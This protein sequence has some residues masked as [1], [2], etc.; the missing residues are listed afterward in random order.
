ML[1][2][3][4][5]LLPSNAICA[6]PDPAWNVFRIV[7]SLFAAF[8]VNFGE[9]SVAIPLEYYSF[10]CPNNYL[11]AEL[12]EDWRKRALRRVCAAKGVS[13]ARLLPITHKSDSA[14][15]ACDWFDSE[16]RELAE[17]TDAFIAQGDRKLAAVSSGS[18]E[19][20]VRDYRGHIRRDH[21]PGNQALLQ[22]HDATLMG[23]APAHSAA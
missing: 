1:L 9:L 15:K 11:A 2:A 4:Q 23:H 19:T 3:I 20:T 8:L 7:P 18:L 16:I 6:G 14:C 10:L 17:I 22:R 5:M 21:G 12:L 13:M